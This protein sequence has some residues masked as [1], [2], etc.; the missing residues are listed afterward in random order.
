MLLAAKSS[1]G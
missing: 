1:D